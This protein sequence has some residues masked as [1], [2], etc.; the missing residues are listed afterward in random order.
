MCDNRG[1]SRTQETKNGMNMAF[2]GCFS[3]DFLGSAFERSDIY[4]IINFSQTYLKEIKELNK[5]VKFLNSPRNPM[6]GM[7]TRAMLSK[8]T[9]HPI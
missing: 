9:A 3:S 7:Q 2:K 4:L 6:A 5:I 8:T 1:E